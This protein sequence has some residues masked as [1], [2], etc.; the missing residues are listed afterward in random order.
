[1]KHLWSHIK[2]PVQVTLVALA[3]NLTPQILLEH[4]QLNQI[5]AAVVHLVED[6]VVW[7]ALELRIVLFLVK[8][9]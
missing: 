7:A 6:S 9:L 4:I 1:M 8:I 5:L 3:I 2:A